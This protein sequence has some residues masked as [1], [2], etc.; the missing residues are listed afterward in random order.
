MRTKATA[1]SGT[2]A[3]TSI[4][5]LAVIALLTAACGGPG[6]A[7]PG[8]ATPGGAATAGAASPGAAGFGNWDEVLAAAKGQT[9]NWYM[10]GGDEK[11]N[12]YVSEWV[13]AKARELGV[14]INRVAVTDTVEAIN[15]V[16]GEKQAGR[17]EGGS[18]DLIWVNGENFRTG[19]QAEIWF[20]GWTGLLP[21]GRHV[22]WND[23]KVANDFG[24]PVEGCESPW[25]SAQFAMVYDSAKVP[26]A[27]KTKRELVDWIKA[28]RGRFTYPAPPD[29]T[30]SVFVRHMFYEAA[31]GYESLL[32]PFDQA[33]FDSVAPKAWDLLNGLEPSLWRQGQT[34]PE[35]LDALND[36]YSNG[37]VYMTM[38][39]GPG[40]V[41][42][43][44][45]EGKY[46]KSTRT[47]VFEEG[48]I[49]NTHYVAIP[50]NAAHRAA[51]MVVANILISP[52]AQYQKAQ[53]SVWGD[54]PAIDVSTAGE[55]QA[56]FEAMPTHPSVLRYEDLSKNAN[57]ELQGDWLEA[58]ETGWK[59][60]V[61]QK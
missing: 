40:A 21:N 8:P 50:Y 42:G 16:L 3:R 48:T 7:S 5:I 17:N 51:A 25:G 10:W 22:N 56:K 45:D 13:N 41:G 55:W 29:F 54:Y 9:V 20:C 30:G 58:I 61:L 27:P 59:E 36:L 28:N 37:E 43:L 12:A 18:V 19:K 26:N 1:G 35:S 32:G 53:A 6:A 57:A 38:T 52:E 31:G 33:K 23:P 14:T 46:P 44:V 2:A 15:K 47:F 11:I 39:Y 4:A 24:V 49:G 60:N 34:Y